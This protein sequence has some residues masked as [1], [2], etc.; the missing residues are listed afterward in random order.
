MNQLTINTTQ[1]VNINFTAASVGQRMLASLIDYL[2]KFA[3]CFL[4]WYVF[5]YWLNI[6]KKF[7]GMDQWSIM[8]ICLILFFPVLIYSLVQETLWEGQTVGKKILQMKVV[9]LDGYQAGFGDYLMRWLFRIIENNPVLL[10]FVL[11]GI[12]SIATTEKI[13][14]LGDMAADTAVISLKNAVTISSTILENIDDRYMPIYP[15]VIK[16]SDNDMRIIKESYQNAKAK[17]DYETIDKL[18][19]KIE[20]VTGIKNQSG[21]TND[22]IKTVLK[23]Y[24]YYTQNM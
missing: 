20:K 13:Q 21:N 17:Q 18:C 6:G 19:L 14:R 9:K 8:S 12:I 24:N 15:A 1:N 4:I 16:L 11:I 7:D 3:Y 23:D 22:F 10:I 2:I 5:F